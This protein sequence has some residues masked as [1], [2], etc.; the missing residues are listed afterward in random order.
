VEQV[1][2]FVAVELPDGLK[3]DLVA[4]QDRLKAGSPSGVR[5]VD[6]HG[7]HLTLKFLGN[8]AAGR[9]PEIVRALRQAARGVSPFHL[10]A[11]GLGVF[12]NTGRVRVVWVGLTGDLEGLRNLQRRTESALAPLGFPAESRPFSPHLTLARVRDQVSPAD[13][14][15]L[16]ALVEGS[17]FESTWPIDVAAVHLMRS[18]LTGRGA[19]YSVIESVA[20]D[21]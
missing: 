19:V 9:L 3:Q 2:C 8:V 20:L 15:G 21:R 6:P 5:W 1:R 4:L 12:P 18:Q 13:R 11:G 16:G 10:T 17:R 14:Q 7:I